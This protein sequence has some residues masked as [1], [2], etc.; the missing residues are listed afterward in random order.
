[1]V[2][3]SGCHVC[4]L[5]VCRFDVVGLEWACPGDM[6]AVGKELRNPGC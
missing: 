2:V 3:G 4:H 1:M 6:Q 5:V